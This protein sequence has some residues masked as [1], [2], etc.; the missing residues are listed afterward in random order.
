MNRLLRDNTGPKAHL[1][2]D[3]FGRALLAYRNNPMQGLGLFP[4][5]NVF[6]RVLKVTLPFA[7]KKGRGARGVE[8]HQRGQGKRHH[9]NVEKLNEH[10][11]EL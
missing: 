7:P 8:D 1:D 9:L 5:K 3:K 4:A 6:G 2:T 11:K 10:V